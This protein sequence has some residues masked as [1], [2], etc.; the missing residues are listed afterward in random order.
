MVLELKNVSKKYGNKPILEHVSFDINKGEI[1]GFLGPNGAG[2]TTTLKIIANLVYP[3]TGKIK[4]MGHDL[5]KERNKALSYIGAVIENPEHYNYL[6]G[7]TNLEMMARMR[8]LPKSRIEEVVALVKMEKRIDDKVKRYS[9]GMK[10]RMGI[11]LALLSKPKL[12]LLDEPTNGLD[13]EGISEFREIIRKVAKEEGISVLISSHQLDEVERLANR[14]VFIEAGKITAS[15]AM[16]S[17]TANDFYMVETDSASEIQAFLTKIPEVMD[18][19]PNAKGYLLKII[20]NSSAFVLAQIVKQDIP[21]TAFYPSNKHL[22]DRYFE[23]MKGGI[24]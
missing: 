11:A 17:L 2:K 12:L 18:C 20:P 13:P 19:Q 15:E 16:D 9:L 21:V 8:K 14:L 1:L 4:I 24:R 5:M 7:R 3:D 22:E 10:Q 6:S 23:L